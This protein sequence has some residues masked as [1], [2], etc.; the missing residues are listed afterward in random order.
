MRKNS[1]RNKN[2]PENLGNSSGNVLPYIF[3]LI[4]NGFLHG[5]LL[6]FYGLSIHNFLYL[7]ISFLFFI[8]PFYYVTDII[9]SL[10]PSVCDILSGN[11]LINR[12]YYMNTARK[13]V[14][15]DS[16]L[17]VTVSIP[18]YMEEN[19]VIFETAIQ[20]LTAINRYEKISGQKSNVIISDDGIAPMLGGNCSEEKVCELLYLL[21]YDSK[22]LTENELKAAKRIDFYR[23]NKIGFVVRGAQNRA[24]LFK[25]SSNLNFTLKLGKLV[26]SGA[27][28]SD[29]LLEHESFQHAYA[30]GDVVTHEII[31]LLDKDSGVHER[32]IEA[33]VPEFSF[34]SRLA[35][36]QCATNA[37][38]MSENYFSYATAHQVN[39]LFLNIWPCKALQ[40]FFVPLVGHNVFLKKSLLEKSG[41][42]A[43]NRVSEDYDKA[44]C[45]YNMGYHGKY[46]QI[47][48]LEFTEFVSRTF[49]EETGKQHRYSYGLFEMIFE[50]TIQKHRTRKCDALYMYLYFFSVVNEVMLLPTVLY[51]SYFGNIHILWAGF[52]FCNICFI[53]L[54]VIR[55]LI[56]HRRMPKES[57]EKMLHTL[58]IAISFVGHS[59][60]MLSGAVRYLINQIKPINSPFPSSSVDKMDYRVREG[61]R[62]LLTFCKKNKAF[63]PICIL[64][65]DRGLFILTRKGIEPVTMFTYCYIL[66]GTILV[67]ILLTPQFFPHANTA[68][69]KS[70]DEDEI[71]SEIITLSNDSNLNAVGLNFQAVSKNIELIPKKGSQSMNHDLDIFLDSYQQTLQNE[72]IFEDIPQRISSNYHFESCIKKEEKKSIYLIRSLKEDTRA[73]LKITEDYPQ[74]DA[75]EEAKLLKKLNHAGIPKLYD[76]FEQSGK[77]YI[78][79]EYIEGRSLQEII[80]SNGSLNT[81]DIFEIVLKLVGILRYLH[82]QVPPVI[83]RDIKPQNIIL[84]KNAGVYLIDFG[85]A[86]VHKEGRTQDTEVILTLNYAPPEQYGFDQ[87]SPLTDIYSMGIVMLYMATSN[88]KRNEL[89]TMIINNSLRNLIERCIALDPKFRIQ[90]VD[91]IGLYIERAI[92]K[93]G[94]YYRFMIAACLVAVCS[95]LFWGSYS[96][97]IYNGEKIGRKSGFDFGYGV[98]YTDGYEDCPTLEFNNE[99]IDTSTQLRGNYNVEGGAYAV[100]GDDKIYYILDGDIYSMS[101]DGMN[102]ELLIKDGH[103]EGLNYREGWLY[104][105]SNLKLVQTNIYTFRSDILSFNTSSH[106]YFEGENYYFIDDSSIYSF[107]LSD[108]KISKIKD[109]PSYQN[110]NLFGE[111]LFFTSQ[112]GDFIVQQLE[113]LKEKSQ[114][115]KSG[116]W[117]MDSLKQNIKGNYKSI[118]IYGDTLYCS[119]ENEYTRLIKIDLKDGDTRM[120]SE[121]DARGIIV[122]KKGIYYIDASNNTI[123]YLST[124]GKIKTRISS[125]RASDFNIAGDWIFYHNREDS[126]KLWC[127]RI[128]GTDEHH[129]RFRR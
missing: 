94:G 60:S 30:E 73:I 65:F 2:I 85:I 49:F 12:K 91:E 54:P 90:T 10:R 104:Y 102:S 53:L 23:K 36:V 50:G 35:Y 5:A 62:L 41:L 61:M 27:E 83:H 121:V 81:R 88:V 100:C 33:I 95:S 127:I 103:A 18:V 4:L 110:L 11:T 39:N 80:K 96:F 51:E 120:I 93:D 25:K 106:L 3:V 28:L 38:N 69:A 124:D 122:T 31:L 44:I 70:Q 108:L 82:S 8:Y 52:L 37:V 19:E 22:S 55:G 64:C 20:S 21:K 89:A 86:R 13:D 84:D 78:I 74:E 1:S 24:G 92:K 42:W 66:F 48:G 118:C 43:Q 76:A 115:S 57:T 126:D 113:H 14:A 16:F 112:N 129:I 114:D 117:D 87:T 125:N 111:Y 119:V 6:I 98:G 71:H 58:I 75:L 72:V 9:W 67:P 26:E 56:M 99:A 40:G 101:K 59:F 128:D 105:N 123:N 34:D 32:I 63:L 68:Q 109:L 47:K 97:G 77:K 116:G 107:E 46:A 79:R 45:F 7:F 29:L 17:P 15:L